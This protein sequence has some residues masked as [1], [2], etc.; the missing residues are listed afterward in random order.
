MAHNCPQYA[1]KDATDIW[2]AAGH[3]ARA[4]YL[5]DKHLIGKVDTPKRFMNLDAD[6]I[7]FDEEWYRWINP[8]NAHRSILV[9]K[10]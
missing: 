1:G 2:G 6:P 10:I 4:R 3:T 8:G 7:E 9:T 5:M